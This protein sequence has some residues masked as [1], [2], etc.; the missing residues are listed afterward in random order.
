MRPG[1]VLVV[2]G[3]NV[4]GTRGGCRLDGWREPAVRD[5]GCRQPLVVE[6]PGTRAGVEGTEGPQI[7]SVLA[8]E[9]G[10]LHLRK[11]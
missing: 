10:T 6:G 3:V 2:K 9:L 7:A 1:G 5:D 8:V 4:A 11:C